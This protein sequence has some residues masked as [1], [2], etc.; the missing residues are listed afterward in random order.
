VPLALPV[1]LA[2]LDEVCMGVKQWAAAGRTQ[3]NLES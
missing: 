2:E 3:I 1:V